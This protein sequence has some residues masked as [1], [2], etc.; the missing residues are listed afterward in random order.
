M[1]DKRQP[2][3]SVA[4]AVRM[5]FYVLFASTVVCIADSAAIL[6]QPAQGPHEALRLFGLDESTMRQFVDGQS[7][8]SDEHEPLFRLLYLIPRLDS[9]DL[10]RWRRP[11]EEATEALDRPDQLRGSI[12]ELRGWVVGLELIELPD[13][14]AQRF[15]YERIYA[16]QMRP[17]SEDSRMTIFSRAIPDAW[18]P[19]LSSR[20]AIEF[21]AGCNAMFI[22]RGVTDDAVPELVFA[23]DRL[24]WFANQIDPTMGVTPGKALLGQAGMDISRFERLDQAKPIG[25]NDR[26]CF[27]ELLW[28]MGRV[29]DAAVAVCSRSDYQIAKLLK[30]PQKQAGEF[31]NLRGLARRAVKIR[32]DDEDVRQRYGI[33]HY[34]EVDVFLSLPQ[35]LSL[36]DPR[37]GESRHYDTFPV[38]FCV[39]ELPLGMPLGPSIRKEI[40][41]CGTY[42][43]TWSYRSH[44]VTGQEGQQG[45]SR[46]RQVSPLLIAR[47][48]RIVAPPYERTHWP[49]TALVSGFIFALTIIAIAGWYYSRGDR[50][51]L[52]HRRRRP[53]RISDDLS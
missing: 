49:E 5:A 51:Y 19:Y 34:Y 3:S 15:D 39:A 37:D 22:K 1:S 53:E 27:Y 25:H 30:E 14:S 44:F 13:E 9:A 48:V 29:D 33:D 45:K 47:T 7:L 40:E 26:E 18:L 46:R 2:S 32:V 21:P 12:F 28:V 20:E 50:A 43:K 36:V 38:T 8:V 4:F 31:Y 11:L 52:A 35:P 42:M 41:V 24:A 10:F 17:V 23:A 16:V 6:A